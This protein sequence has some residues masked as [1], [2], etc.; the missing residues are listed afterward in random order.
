MVVTAATLKRAKEGLTAAR[1]QNVRSSIQ[2]AFARMEVIIQG[3]LEARASGQLRQTVLRS[4]IHSL[5]NVS[6]E[7]IE[8]FLGEPAILVSNHLSH[9][10]PFL[11]LS[12]IPPHPYYYILGDART[13]YNH[14]WK[15][16]TL[17]WAGGVIP[18][19]RHWKEEIAIINAAQ[20]GCTELLDFASAIENNVPSGKSIQT[21]RQIDQAVQSILARGD[22][23]LLFPEGRLGEKEGYLNPLKRG[24]AIYALRSGVPVIPVALSG[25]HDLYLRKK[26]T[27]RFGSPLRFSQIHRPKPNDV[28]TALTQIQVSMEKLLPKHYHEP[29]GLKLCRS[30]L[31][32]MLW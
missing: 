14:F 19:E 20:A 3:D 29:S 25:T 1:D 15:R 28:Q 31:N 23:I 11:V 10:D 30:F 27:L 26:I 13:L 22:G 9:I 6:V 18:L 8:N 5:F 12:E 17:N 7:G 4:L 2:R 32:H 21:L 16:C 24:I